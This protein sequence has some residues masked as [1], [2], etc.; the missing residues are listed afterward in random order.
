MWLGKN[1]VLHSSRPDSAGVM[2]PIKDRSMWGFGANISWMPSSNIAIGPSAV[3]S[4][5]NFRE[6]GKG[7]TADTVH[8]RE[9]ILMIPLALTITIDPIP[10]YKI[11][12]IGHLSLGYNSV[13]INN[14]EERKDRFEGV[15]IKDP[16]GYYNGVFI[17][18]GADLMIDFGKQFSVFAGP[19]VQ[20]SEV[21]RRSGGL[22]TTR[23]FNQ[24]GFRFGVSIL[25]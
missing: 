3:I 11:H 1:E 13:F 7:E 16:D 2:A 6:T 10:Q 14:K 9:L 20:I 19:Q 4:W 5:S 8:S 12:P 22:R 18:F 21:S 15:S 25:L 23:N 17:K 24:S